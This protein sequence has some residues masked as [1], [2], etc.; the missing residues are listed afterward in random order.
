MWSTI[1]NSIKASPRLQQLE[2]D[3]SKGFLKGDK[4]LMGCVGLSD[5]NHVFWPLVYV[6]CESENHENVTS[7]LKTSMAILHQ[8]GV[9]NVQFILKDGGSALSSG[10]DALNFY[11]KMKAYPC[12][13]PTKCV[14]HMFRAGFTRGGGYQ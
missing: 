13:H 6:V 4:L 1:V 10:V 11:L 12:I 14:A 9:N 5:M 3:F 8:C 7:T 2:I